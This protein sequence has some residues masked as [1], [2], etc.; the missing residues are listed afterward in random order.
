[1]ALFRRDGST[2]KE[3]AKI[4]AKCKFK[5]CESSAHKSELNPLAHSIDPVYSTGLFLTVLSAELAAPA[6][7]D[8][9]TG[10]GRHRSTGAGKGSGS[11]S[12]AGYAAEYQEAFDRFLVLVRAFYREDF[13]FGALAKDPTLRQGLVALCNPDLHVY[14]GAADSQVITRNAGNGR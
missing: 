4:A 1:M 3:E 10:S 12:F 13:S 6:I 8:A 11:P 5:E 7:H 9:L 14:P 2:P